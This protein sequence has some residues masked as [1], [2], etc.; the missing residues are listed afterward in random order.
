MALVYKLYKRN[1]SIKQLH[2]ILIGLGNSARVDI[3]SH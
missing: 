1:D 3:Y 2:K